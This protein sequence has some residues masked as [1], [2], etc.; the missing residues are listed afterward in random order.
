MR[1]G[2]AQLKVVPNTTWYNFAD[3]EAESFELLREELNY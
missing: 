3:D 1:R 2:L